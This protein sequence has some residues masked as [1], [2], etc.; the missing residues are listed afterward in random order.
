[1]NAKVKLLA[2]RSALSAKAQAGS[3]MIVEDFTFDAPKT[4]AFQ[5]ILAALQVADKKPLTVTPEYDKM[6][7]LSA[8]NI[9]RSS[10]APASD[11]NTY[12]IMNAGTIVIAES[13]IAKITESCS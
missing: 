8:R 7:Y 2:R 6:L 3:I 13:A 4:K 5:Q 11:L 9:E 1:V 10:I 12:Q